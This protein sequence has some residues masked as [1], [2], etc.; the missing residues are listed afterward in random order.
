MLSAGA[1]QVHRDY[2]KSLIYG[3]LHDSKKP[4]HL[5]MNQDMNQIHLKTQDASKSIQQI[6]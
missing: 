3:Y 6:F 5:H 4:N 1:L 2:G